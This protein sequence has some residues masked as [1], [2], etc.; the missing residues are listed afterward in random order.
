MK[1]IYIYTPSNVQEAALVISHRI[2][3][4]YGEGAITCPT[5]HAAA[6]DDFAAV[7]H[8]VAAGAGGIVAPAHTARVRRR[9][10][11]QRSAGGVAIQRGYF[12]VTGDVQCIAGRRRG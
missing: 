2:D 10:Q 1:Y 5:A 12:V 7:W 11:P 8:A 9:R 3:N 4:R 6:V